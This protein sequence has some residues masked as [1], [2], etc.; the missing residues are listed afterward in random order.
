ML[1]PNVWA[2]G[3]IL[4]GLVKTGSHCVGSR[5]MLTGQFEEGSYCI[6]SRHMARMVYRVG[7]YLL[8]G[9][10]LFGCGGVVHGCINE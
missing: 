9:M 10:G 5:R 8:S 7:H 2:A 1:D 3:R 4:T 6:G